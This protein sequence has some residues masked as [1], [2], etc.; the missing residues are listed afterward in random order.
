[1]QQ[2]ETIMLIASRADS[3]LEIN[4]LYITGMMGLRVWA[5]GRDDLSWSDISGFLVSG[6]VHSIL[7]R[8]TLITAI[9]IHKLWLSTGQKM[10]F[11]MMI[12]SSH[13]TADHGKGL[14]KMAIDHCPL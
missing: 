8:L 13:G 12:T 2:N 4:M 7:C 9:R 1:M 11:I 14:A 5:L 3:G 6:K 10:L